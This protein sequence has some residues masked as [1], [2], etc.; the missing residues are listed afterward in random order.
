MSNDELIERLG[1]AQQ[2]VMSLTV[3][4]HALE[5]RLEKFEHRAEELE[6]LVRE[7]ADYLQLNVVRS[8]IFKR[9]AKVMER[10]DADG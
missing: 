6:E 1:K 4:K 3:H 10:L 8:A 9:I 5:K 2:Q 7:V